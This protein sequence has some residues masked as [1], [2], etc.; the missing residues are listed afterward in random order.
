M[1][2]FRIS[3]SSAPSYL[4]PGTVASGAPFAP[5]R[6]EAGVL[7]WLFDALQEH[8]PCAHRPPRLD[9]TSGKV[10]PDGDGARKKGPQAIGRSR[11]G[12]KVRPIAANDR[13]ALTFG[14]CGGNAHKGRGGPPHRRNKG[15]GHT[16][17]HGLQHEA[18]ARQPNCSCMTG[19]ADNRK[20]RNRQNRQSE[21]PF[22]RCPGRCDAAAM[23]KATGCRNAAAGEG[24]TG[25]GAFVCPA[26]GRRNLPDV[27]RQGQKG[28]KTPAKS[29]SIVKRSGGRRTGFRR[30][31]C[32]D[33][34]VHGSTG[35]SAR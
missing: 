19:K 33:R 21:Q 35:G 22:R 3:W 27:L 10:R 18:M 31:R 17:R 30:G 12:R 26:K 13:F 34:R 25:N 11:G 1:R 32:P 2:G 20:A 23:S 8:D 24:G 6:A 29:F 16:R 28:G 14:F 4:P 15:G 5:H 9:G 7:G